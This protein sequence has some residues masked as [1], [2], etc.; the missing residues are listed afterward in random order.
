MPSRSPPAARLDDTIVTQLLVDRP[1]SGSRIDAEHAALVSLVRQAANDPV[2]LLQCLVDLAVELCEAGSAGV[3]LLQPDADADDVVFRWVAMAGAYRGYVGGTT[4]RSFSPCG[5]C[6]S[7]DAPQLYRYPSRVF[8]YLSKA[9]PA[10]VEGLVIPLRTA[11]GVLGTIWVVTHDETRVFTARELAVMTTLADFASTALALQGA[12][13]AAEASNRAK[14]EF[15][16]I[17]SHELRRPLMA[18][19]G[20]SELLLEGRV[21]AETATRAIAALHTNARRQQQMIDDLLDASR[22]ATGALCLT[23]GP[24]DVSAVVRS[25]IEVVTDGARTKGV[26]L[27]VG[28]PDSIPFLGD[29]ARLQQVMDNV[30][31]NALKFT[32]SGGRICVEAKVALPWIEIIVRDTGA[33]IAPHLVPLVFDAFRKADA[34]S[35]QRESGLGLGL[36]IAR[37]LVDLHAGRV[38]VRSDGEGCGAVVT[39]TLPAVRLLAAAA[40]TGSPRAS[41]DARSL[42]ELTILVVDDEK[43]VRD[44]LTYVLEEAGANVL[45]VGGVD[46]ALRALSG[47]HVDELLSDIVM[48]RQDGYDLVAAIRRQPGSTRPPLAIAVTALA[49]SAERQRVLAAGFDHHVAKP[50]EFSQLLRLIAESRRGRAAPSAAPEAPC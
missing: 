34:S 36:T 5:V 18:M 32:P 39:V 23:E 46:D 21:T 29:P 48:P 10:I 6:L 2:G 42:F 35:T 8:T 30:L 31:G 15:L 7:R 28:M 49:S 43:D 17:V 13:E 38:D 14:D 45:A 9:E 33:G 37:R 41:P 19:V 24:M 3:S 50:V 20:W 47:R 16:A 26:E 11:A 4:P 44:I 1:P 25:A 40:P 22:S 27:V 12:R